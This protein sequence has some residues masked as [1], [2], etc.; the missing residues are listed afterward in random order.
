ME[1]LAKIFPRNGQLFAFSI[2]ISLREKSFSQEA[3]G[4][5]GENKKRLPAAELTGFQVR[6]K[7]FIISQH[8]AGI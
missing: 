3:E 7:K 2:Q 5:F 8:S 1:I 6:G 4:Y